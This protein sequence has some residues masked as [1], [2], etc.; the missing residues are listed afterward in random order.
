M[1]KVDEVD[2]MECM[3]NDGPTRHHG[4]SKSKV[5]Q[6]NNASLNNGNKG[7]NKWKCSQDK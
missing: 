3:E 1:L 6:K 2:G 7:Q 5:A 4:E